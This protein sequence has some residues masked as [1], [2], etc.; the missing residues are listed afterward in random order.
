[1]KRVPF[2]IGGLGICLFIILGGAVFVTR[3]DSVTQF[4]RA[5]TI[6]VSTPSREA[7]DTPPLESEA[8]LTSAISGTACENVSRRPFAVMMAGDIGTRP[9]SGIGSADLVIEM[10]VIT[11][12]ITRYMAVFQ[13]DLPQEIGSLRSA[14]HDFIPLAMSF[15]A[16]FV[17]WGGS[18]YALDKLNRGITDNINALSNSYGAFYRKSGIPKPHNGFTSA[19]K[20]AYAVE[21]L[22]Y[23]LENTF[24][25]YPH[26]TAQSPVYSSPGVLTI[27]YPYPFMVRYDYNPQT[28]GYF[29]T[30]GNTKEIDKVSGAQ[31]ET[32]NVV[33]MRAA[34]RQIEGQYNDVDVEGS[35]EAFIYRGG[36]EIKGTWSKDAQSPK[37]K[38]Y[39][40]DE[41]GSEI[42]FTPGSIWVEIVEPYQIVKWTIPNS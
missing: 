14:R 35:G 15:D 13:C 39:F 7:R 2:L 33:I 28:N 6:V 12:S 34:S 40:F 21:R 37:S 8:S 41:A 1:M 19:D 25:G 29:R 18:H 16:I 20:L 22:G 38:L 32:K 3:F 26:R 24:E 10:P 9:L 11:G 31:V 27:G 36:E 30:R 17:H 5:S 42:E 23:R 4:F